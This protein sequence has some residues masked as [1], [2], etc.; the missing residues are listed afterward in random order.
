MHEL[1]DQ[2]INCISLMFLGDI[3][4]SSSLTGFNLLTNYVWWGSCQKRALPLLHKPPAEVHLSPSP[5]GFH[6]RPLPLHWVFHPPKALQSLHYTASLEFFSGVFLMQK[7]KTRTFSTK[8][9]NSPMPHLCPTPMHLLI[10][11]TGQGSVPGTAQITYPH[12]TTFS[13]LTSKADLGSSCIPPNTDTHTEMHTN[14][15]TTYCKKMTDVVPTENYCGKML[16]YQR[17]SCTWN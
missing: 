9:I 13:S 7:Q 1:N 4:S 12:N 10:K 11:Q 14:A 5:R 3:Q 17:K 15:S 6:L 8:Y 2:M 16:G